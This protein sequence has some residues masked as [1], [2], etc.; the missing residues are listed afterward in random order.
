VA[1]TNAD[2]EAARSNAGTVADYIDSMS[3]LYRWKFLERRDS[4]QLNQEAVEMLKEQ[5]SDYSVLA[6]SAQ[7][8]EDCSKNIPVLGLLSETTGLEVRAFGGIKIDPLSKESLWAI[9]P[10]PP[11]VLTFGVEKLP[12]IIIFDQQ[13]N[14]IG[15]IIEN[16]KHTSTIEEEI[17][18][19]LNQR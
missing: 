10:S 18:F 8:C 16:P 14:E 4:Y 1:L 7:W 11:E 5:A 9:P 19:L 12:W 13:N 15:K 2:I 17:V 3:K 6:F